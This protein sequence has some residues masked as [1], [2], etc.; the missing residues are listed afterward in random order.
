M[1]PLLE[2]LS[3]STDCSDMDKL[4]GIS[5]TIDDVEYELSPSDYVLKI[6]AFGISECVLGLMPVDLPESFN[7]FI[8]GDLFMRRYYTYFDQNNDRL[9]FYDA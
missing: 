1:G 3:V 2:G 8:L 7:Y 6:N 9:G 4:P 5:F